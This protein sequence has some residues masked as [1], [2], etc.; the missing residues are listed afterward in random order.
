MGNYV[1]Q[2]G[3]LV[4]EAATWFRVDSH[5]H[6]GYL[7]EVWVTEREYVEAVQHYCP[8]LTHQLA[9]LVGIDERKLTGELEPDMEKDREYSAPVVRNEDGSISDLAAQRHLERE[10]KIA[11]TPPNEREVVDASAGTPGQLDR[12]SPDNYHSDGGSTLFT[13]EQAK[14]VEELS[15]EPEGY[16]LPKV[17]VEGRDEDGNKV[18]PEVNEHAAAAEPA[19]EVRTKDEPVTGTFKLDDEPVV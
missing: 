4:P 6:T 1:R 8:D 7:D 18:V 19:D 9:E 12:D 2:P 13:D 17:R 16:E 10:R 11:G 5:V 14:L 15:G 3:A